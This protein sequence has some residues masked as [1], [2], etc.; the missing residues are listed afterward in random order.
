[1]DIM[2]AEELA[3]ELVGAIHRNI[4]SGRRRKGEIASRVDDTDDE[5]LL[6]RCMCR[7]LLEFLQVLRGSKGGHCTAKLSK[8][9][10]LPQM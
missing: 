8:G 5:A 10:G 4:E 6:E 9:S 1:M 2:P 3:E 7:P